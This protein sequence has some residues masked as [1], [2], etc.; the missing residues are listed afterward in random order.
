M[1]E[2]SPAISRSWVLGLQPVP[3]RQVAI[4]DPSPAISRSWVLGLQPV[5][6]RQVA[7]GDPSPAISRSWVLGLQPVPG[8][9]VAI[10]DPS[11][12]VFGFD[13]VRR[14]AVFA[15]CNEMVSVANNIA[16]TYQRFFMAYLL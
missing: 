13:I 5:P 12:A 11:P 4:G 7:I 2:P 1:G 8:R 16:A 14:S 10:G 6:G 9:Q 3:G 15:A